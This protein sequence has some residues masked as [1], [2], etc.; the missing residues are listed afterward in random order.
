MKMYFLNYFI[1]KI[2][3]SNSNSHWLAGWLLNTGPDPSPGQECKAL[4]I[5]LIPEIRH[6]IMKPAPSD[7]EVGLNAMFT[8]ILTPPSSS[9]QPHL[10]CLNQY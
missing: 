10:I 7:T 5:G 6:Q 8:H 9:S 3:G 4:S 2:R 1:L